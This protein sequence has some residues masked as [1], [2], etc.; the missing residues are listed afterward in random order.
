MV[1][2]WRFRMCFLKIK[3]CCRILSST[4]AVTQNDGR[5]MMDPITKPD[6]G[7]GDHRVEK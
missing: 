2:D 5:F 1:S 6:S 4:A 7:S 3:R